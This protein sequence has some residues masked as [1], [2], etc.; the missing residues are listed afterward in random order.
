MTSQ[1]YVAARA[2][3]TMQPAFSLFFLLKEREKEEHNSLELLKERGVSRDDV[4]Q[5]GTMSL[6]DRLPLFL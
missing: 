3:N 2:D 1:S 4:F 6:M 5:T